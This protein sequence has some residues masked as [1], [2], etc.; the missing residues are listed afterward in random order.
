MLY[1]AEL[2][3]PLTETPWNEQHVRDAIRGIVAEADAAYDP[4]TLWPAH[5]WDGWG[6]ALPLKNLYVGAT[7]PSDPG[8]RERAICQWSHRG[9]RLATLGRQAQL[10]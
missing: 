6:A 8:C 4:E 5:E 9:P 10:N 7:A 3:Q 1:A 2:H